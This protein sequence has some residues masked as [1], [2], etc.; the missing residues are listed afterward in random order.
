MFKSCYGAV[1]SL[2][3]WHIRESEAVYAKSQDCC[4]PGN[5]QREFGGWVI[6]YSQ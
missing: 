2:T 6:D 3:S 4:N 1:R 5:V